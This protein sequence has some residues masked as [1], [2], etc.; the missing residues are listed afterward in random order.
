V[1]SQ[2]LKLR[3]GKKIKETSN[4]DKKA[5][6]NHNVVTADDISSGVNKS[7]VVRRCLIYPPNQSGWNAA[8]HSIH[9]ILSDSW[10]NRGT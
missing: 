6:G 2:A 1:D 10:H 8:G 9:E 7:T 5:D 3:H 4:K